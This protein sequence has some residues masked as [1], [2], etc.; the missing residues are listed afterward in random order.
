MQPFIHDRV[1]AAPDTAS[2][3][4]TSPVVLVCIDSYATTDATLKSSRIAPLLAGPTVAQL[5]NL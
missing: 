1:A 2:A 4:V 3:I 5:R